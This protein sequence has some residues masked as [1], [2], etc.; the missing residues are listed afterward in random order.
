VAAVTLAHA[1]LLGLLLLAPATPEP[2]TPPRTLT[3]SLI[4]PKAPQP[5]PAPRPQPPRSMVKQLP[6]PP[7]LA[8]Q[9]SLP[10]PPQAIEAPMP[11]VEPEPAPDLS[12]PPE[13]VAAETP[14]ALPPPPTPPHP[15]DYL[16]NPKPPYPALSKRLGEEGSVR[17]KVLI[18]A[19]GS[20]ARLEMIKSSGHPRLDRS[21]METVPSWKFVPA[22]QGGRP[23]ADW[24][25]VPIQFTLRS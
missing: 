23:I 14:A 6:A 19:D 8:A 21:A 2:A 12:P 1:G 18:N 10:T 25:T 7:V 3:V 22:H 20:V 4:V 17:L 9:R 13:P 5:Q 24:V 16:N 11:V 15:A